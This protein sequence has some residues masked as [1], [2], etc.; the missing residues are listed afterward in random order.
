MYFIGI[1]QHKQYSQLTVLDE[2]GQ[3]V[4]AGRVLNLRQEVEG[5]LEGLGSE[6][7]A[8]VEAG[9]S[10]YVMVDLMGALGVRVKIAHPFQVKAI[11]KARIKNDKRDS[12]ILAHLLRTGLIPEIYQ[13]EAHNREAQRVLRLRA[14][15]IKCLT[16]V[17][18]KIW[19]LLV[20][21]QE[22]IR[23][24][25]ERRGNVF[26][27][28]G[29]E[30]LDALELQG[31]DKEIL[32]SLL[33]IYRQLREGLKESDALVKSLYQ[34]MEEARLI[35][36][37]PG[38]AQT[39]SVLVAVELSDIDRFEKVEQLHSYAGLVPSTRSSGEKTYHGRIT[40]QGNKW[41]RW[42]VVEAVYPAI[43]ADHD[44]RVFY[45][46]IT[47]RK[48]ANV[49]KVATARRLLTIIYKLLKEKRV[50]IPYKRD[51]SRLPKT[52]TNEPKGL[53]SSLDL[54]AETEYYKVCA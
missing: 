47:R 35:D 37:V 36:T 11:A 48:G 18:N 38:F 15:Y 13:R 27:R 43:R 51:K 4:K 19:S 34:E 42:A 33:R 32:I 39:L 53:R 28:K 9:R 29:L 20:Q 45:Q 16:Q 40:K 52:I 30:F 54:G 44:L 2:E 31:K 21:Q 7:E 5:F 8:V 12:R 6:V 17:R 25:V 3:E 41:L 50:Y 1:D 22:D 14:F 23:M 46:R 24:E 26:T 10:C 49:A